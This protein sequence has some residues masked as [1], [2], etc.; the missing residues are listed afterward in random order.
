MK[1]IMPYLNELKREQEA[2]KQ[3]QGGAN[4]VHVDVL[5]NKPF[6][7]TFLFNQGTFARDL[8]NSLVSS[9]SAAA[10]A[11]HADT[12]T[13]RQQRRLNWAMFGIHPFKN[14]CFISKLYS[15]FASN[16]CMFGL[17]SPE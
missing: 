11:K 17:T 5:R 9:P 8:L 12:T 1:A 14:Q 2:L 15:D 4:V 10:A 16:Q 6:E 7:H 13:T 3:A